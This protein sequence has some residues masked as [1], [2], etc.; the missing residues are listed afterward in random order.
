MSEPDP[1]ELGAEVVSGL[2]ATSD[3]R[4]EMINA[5]YTNLCRDLNMDRQT[6]LQGYETY[7]EVSQ[8]C[9][10]EVSFEVAA[11]ASNLTSFL[12][13][14]LC[15]ACL[16]GHSQPLDVLRHLHGLPKNQH[17]HGDWPECSGQG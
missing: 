3:D 10:M 4:L 13:F 6:E 11:V 14:F 8:R 5:E 15:I 9:S 2:V 7:L 1:Q 16:K 17:T 12:S